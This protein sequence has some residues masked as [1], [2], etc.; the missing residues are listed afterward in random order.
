MPAQQVFPSPGFPA[1]PAIR[2]SPPEGWIQRVVPDALGA[3][4][5]PERAGEYTPNVV[6]SVSRRTPGYLLQDIA[7]SVDGFLA[8]LPDAVL[9]G[10]EPAAINGREWHIREARYAHPEAGSLTQFTAVTVVDQEVAV[11]VVQLTGSCRAGE[12]SEDIKAIYALVAST[13][14]A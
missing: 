9:L 10:T 5:G 4:M 7:G 13:E 14:I 12:G 6:I 11:D 2:V 1:Y 8:T 3:L